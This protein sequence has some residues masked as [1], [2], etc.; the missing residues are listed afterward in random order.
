MAVEKSAVFQTWYVS[1][2]TTRYCDL[3]SRWNFAR[4]F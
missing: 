2:D 4:G 1:T 3:E